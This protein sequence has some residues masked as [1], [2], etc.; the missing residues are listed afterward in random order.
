MT[1]HKRYDPVTGRLVF[2]LLILIILHLIMKLILSSLKSGFIRLW[3]WGSS[4]NTE[5]PL[6]LYFITNLP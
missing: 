6:L 3:N 1:K 5:K 4:I 2:I